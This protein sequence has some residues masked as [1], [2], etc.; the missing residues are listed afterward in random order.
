MCN[1]GVLLLPVIMTRDYFGHNRDYLNCFIKNTSLAGNLKDYTAKL[2][3]KKTEAKATFDGNGHV[4]NKK[5][6]NLSKKNIPV[7]IT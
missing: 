1:D 4:L 2:S 7:G 3:I 6:G 5:K